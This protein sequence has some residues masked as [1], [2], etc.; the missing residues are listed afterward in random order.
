M[1]IEQQKLDPVAEAYREL[2]FRL[3]HDGEL[4]KLSRNRIPMGLQE[5]DPV[6]VRQPGFM[7]FVDEQGWPTEFEDIIK[8]APTFQ[9]DEEFLSLLSAQGDNFKNWI[10]QE[11]NEDRGF[12]MNKYYGSYPAVLRANVIA[13]EFM[14]S[15]RIAYNSLPKVR[16]HPSKE[17]L[18]SP[19]AELV[20]RSAHVAY[21]LLSR[22]IKVDDDDRHSMLVLGRIDEPAPITDA[23]EYLSR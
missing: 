16:Q 9:S 13:P 15:L 5:L 1:S 11:P 19:E 20:V 22:L 10:S 4:I 17:I 7:K 8:F 14:D 2:N 12:D 21:R 18:H 23:G 3:N 6:L